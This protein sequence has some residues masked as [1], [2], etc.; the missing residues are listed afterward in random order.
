MLPKSGWYGRVWQ[1][2][3]EDITGTVLDKGIPGK[4]PRGRPRI[5]WTDNIRRD[6][7]TWPRRPIDGREEGMVKYLGHV[8]T[9]DLRDDNYIAR[10]YKRIYARGFNPEILYI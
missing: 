6:V 8:T 5:R 10:Q 7:K 4:R 3:P 2:D 9:D 1:R